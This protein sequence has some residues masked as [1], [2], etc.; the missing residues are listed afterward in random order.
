MTVLPFFVERNIPYSIIFFLYSMVVSSAAVCSCY[1]KHNILY[2]SKYTATFENPPFFPTNLNEL[3]EDAG[4]AVRVALISQISRIRVDVR[5]RLVCR[6]RYMFNWLLLMTQSLLDEEFTQIRLFIDQEESRNKC[7]EVL[8]EITNA[9]SSTKATSSPRIRI[10]STSDINLRKADKLIVI[11]SPDNVIYDRPQL[12]E[13]VQAICFHGALR[14]IPVV[15]VNP[16]L[17]STAWSDYGPRTPLLLS[18]FSQAYFACD[19]YFMLS[20]RDKWCGIVQRAA[21]GF[22]LFLLDGMHPGQMKPDSYARI[23]SWPEGIPD[24][25]RSILSDLLMRDPH[26]PMHESDQSSISDPS[27]AGDD[28][29]VRM[30]VVEQTKVPN[31]LAR[32]GGLFVRDRDADRRKSEVH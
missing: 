23:Q 12:L 1:R 31:I 2:S 9:S 13:E 6:E 15:M 16:N 25:I 18:D 21:S 5:M 11:Y 30:E 7:I 19:D 20:R 29:V 10:S 24:N 28:G 4:F 32:R 8:D 3:A 22:D 26:F 14:K 27:A 17:V